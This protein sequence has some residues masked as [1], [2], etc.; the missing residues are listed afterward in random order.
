MSTHP[1]ILFWKRD[2]PD[3][4]Q[5]ATRLPWKALIING[6]ICVSPATA[7]YTDEVPLARMNTPFQ[8]PMGHNVYGDDATEVQKANA[9]FIVRACN[10]HDELLSALKRVAAMVPDFDCATTK[11]PVRLRQLFHDTFE[12]VDAAIAKATA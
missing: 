6:E 10:V 1:T 9:G 8:F 5:P 2:F 7:P 11:E 3:A 4:N 12:M